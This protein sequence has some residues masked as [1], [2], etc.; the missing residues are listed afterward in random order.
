MWRMRLAVTSWLRIAVLALSMSTAVSAGAA[1]LKIA[2]S[3]L[4]QELDLCRQAAEAWARAR[5]HTVDVVST[6]NDGSA[7]L[8]LF[9]QV[10]ASGSDKIDVFQ[11]DVAQVGLLAKHLHDLRKHSQGIERS[12]FKTI[13][14]TV[15]ID[16]RLAAMPWFIDAGLLYYRRDLLE[17]HGQAVPQTWTALKATASLIQQREREAGHKRLWGYVWQGRAYEGLTCNALEW[18]ASHGGGTLVDPSGAVTVGNAQTV[19]AL[20]LMASMVGSV[21][22][23]AVLNYSEEE[24]RGPFQ[25]GNAVFM[26]NWP[27]AWAATQAADSP[28]RGKVGVAVLPRGSTPGSRHAAALGGQALAVSRYSRNTSLAADLVIFMTH[29]DVQ[30]QRAV[31]GSYNPSIEG[32]YEDADVLKAIPFSDQLR[33]SVVGAAARPTNVAGSFY[34]QLSTEVQKSVHEVLS[35]TTSSEEAVARLQQRLRLLSRDGRWQ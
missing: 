33:Q 2:C 17:K 26:R 6:P 24:T 8:A 15:E 23:A 1:T 20:K 12:H 19:E 32:L 30:K 21:S 28:V 10:L 29:A 3:G 7:R 13:L 18:I 27:Y 4:G 31:A 16:G 9:Q 14:S 11:V 5:G 35:S 25:S 22:P 34:N